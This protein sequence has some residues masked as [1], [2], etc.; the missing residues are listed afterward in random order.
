MPDAFQ[1]PPTA[2]VLR[3][4]AVHSTLHASTPR[5]RLNLGSDRAALPVAYGDSIVIDKVLAASR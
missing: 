2:P 3:E 1:L 5:V 4:E